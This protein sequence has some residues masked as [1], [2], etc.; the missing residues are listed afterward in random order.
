MVPSPPSC[1]PGQGASSN[2]NLQ[3][4][5]LIQFES[6]ELEIDENYE[7]VIDINFPS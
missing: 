6:S 3:K 2:Q 5:K 4:D 1:A 7:I